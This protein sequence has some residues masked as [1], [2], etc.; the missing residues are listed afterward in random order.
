MALVEV[1]SG[2]IGL[3]VLIVLIFALTLTVTNVFLTNAGATNVSNGGANL[4][5][6]S[7]TLATQTPL[8]IVLAFIFVPVAAFAIGSLK[9]VG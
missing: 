6:A 1:M 2:G 9:S 4:S 5:G 7:W 8:L 3:S